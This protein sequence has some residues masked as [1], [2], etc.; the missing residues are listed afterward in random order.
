LDEIEVSGGSWKEG[1]GDGLGGREVSDSEEA[2]RG[3]LSSVI[4]FS[5]FFKEL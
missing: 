1:D 5:M 4:D 3:C 2:R